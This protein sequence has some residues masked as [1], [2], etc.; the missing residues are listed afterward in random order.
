MVCSPEILRHP[1][2][3]DVG[4]A[5]GGGNAD[6]HILQRPAEAAH[7][8]ALEMGQQQAWSRSAVNGHLQSSPSDACLR[9]PE[10]KAPRPHP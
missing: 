2:P 8:V 6:G 1:H 7:G 10:S 4:L 3:M 5:V 9:S